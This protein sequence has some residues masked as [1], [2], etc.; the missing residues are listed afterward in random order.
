MPLTR[1]ASP[2][3]AALLVLAILASPSVLIAGAV[4]VAALVD[5]PG[6]GAP[7]PCLI[8]GR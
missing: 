2:L 8:A 4:Q 1:R 3:S 7:T 5:A 6:C